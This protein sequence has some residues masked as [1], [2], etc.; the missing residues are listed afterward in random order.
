NEKMI[1]IFDD[2]YT[3][4]P[5]IVQDIVVNCN[6]N[7]LFKYWI[8]EKDF[9]DLLNIFLNQRKIEVFEEVN[10]VYDIVFIL[11]DSASKDLSKIESISIK[12]QKDGESNVQLRQVCDIF[13]SSASSNIFRFNEQF[14]INEHA[15]TKP[16]VELNQAIK[17]I[18]E[19]N[20]NLPDG[21]SISYSEKTKTLIELSEFFTLFILVA[22]I[23]LYLLM[24]ARFNSFLMP[25]IILSSVPVC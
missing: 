9:A 8:T 10:N 25:V 18:E 2:F 1:N 19:I 5:G 21:S 24:Y 11:D 3:I 4:S 12:N 15:V 22:L 13:K 7:K 6:K 16:N 23:G 17:S 20:D 14:S